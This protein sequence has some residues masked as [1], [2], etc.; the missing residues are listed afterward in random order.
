[1]FYYLLEGDNT[2]W[3]NVINGK[4]KDKVKF[5]YLDPPY[6]TKRQRGVRKQYQDHFSD[7]NKM[8]QQVLKAHEY[9][10]DDG[11]LCVSINQTELFNLKE[12][13]DKIFETKNKPNTFIG[14][15]PVKIRHSS[16]QLMINA[17]FHN[18]FEYLLV[19]R[20]NP[21]TKFYNRIKGPDMS[22]FVYQVKLKKDKNAMKKIINGKQIEI[23]NESDYEIIKGDS[24]ET[25]FRRYIIAGKIATANWSGEFYEKHLK[26]FGNNK[27][28]KVHDLE[29][30]GLGY[31]WFLTGNSKRKSGVY[32][33]STKTA[34]KPQLL[35]NDFDYTDVVTNVYKEGG[36]GIDFKDSKKPEELINIL[37]ERTTKRGDLVMDLFAGSGTTLAC[38]IKKGRSCLTIEKNKNFIN[39]IK[40]RLE[41]IKNGKDI[42]EKKY[43]FKY[44]YFKDNIE[45]KKQ[46]EKLHL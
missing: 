3:F 31:R 20:K 37:L 19:Y 39:I 35:T 4:F 27:L 45:F 36:D 5:I 42:N 44:K 30:K 29:K 46:L 38:C 43:K 28:I 1:M 13:L 12:V 24:L 21:K 6:N 40:K 11:F 25:K 32:F 15:F 17:T 41:N 26:S 14:L 34:G 9:L 18:V 16:R 7:W 10:S 23:Y 2:L 8:M 33:Q 22:K